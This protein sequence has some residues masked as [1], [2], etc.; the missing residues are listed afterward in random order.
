[1]VKNET[2]TLPN[3][4]KPSLDMEDYVKSIE[5]QYA[6][7]AARARD[8][9]ERWNQ[10]KVRLISNRSRLFITVEVHYVNIIPFPIFRLRP[11]FKVQ[12]RRSRMSVTKRE[13]S[14]TFCGKSRG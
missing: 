9:A 2:V 3:S 4:T 7:M 1:M 8:E 5:S 13:T 12:D 10:R 6:E 11:W 14:L